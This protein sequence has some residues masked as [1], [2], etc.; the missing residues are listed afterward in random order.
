MSPTDDDQFESHKRFAASAFNRAWELIEK[1]DRSGDDDMEMLAA[2]VA[3]RFHWERVGEDEQ[4]VVGDWQIAHVASL[5]GFPDLALAYARASLDRAVT[6]GYAGWRLASCYEGMAR[7]NAAAGH[8]DERDRFIGLAESALE[9]E[10]NDE[11]RDVIAS[12]LR[13]IPG[14]AD[15]LPD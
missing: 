5:L 8:M 13:S 11:E 10:E 6:N 14:Y 12:Q 9:A 15:P 7:A 4:R 3:S 2:A 1:P